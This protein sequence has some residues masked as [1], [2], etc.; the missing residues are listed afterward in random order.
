MDLLLKNKKLFLAVVLVTAFI[1]HAF[2]AFRF[3][4][5]GDSGGWRL[6]GKTGLYGGQFGMG[7]ST[8]YDGDCPLL[9]SNWPPLTYHYYIGMRWVYENLNPMQLPQWGFYKLFPVIASVG[10]GYLIYKFAL[11]YRLKNPIFFTA[12]Y[13]FHPLSLYV[14]AYHGQRESVWL[15]FLLLSL[16]IMLKFKRYFWFAVIFAVS[17]SIKLPPLL[18]APFLFLALPTLRNKTI[19]IFTVPF[20]F[21]LLS[22]PEI[23][24][25]TENVFRQVFLYRGEVGWWGFAGLAAKIDILIGSS[26]SDSVG[27]INKALQYLI[28]ISA[29]FYFYRRKFNVLEGILGVLII[30][31]V[32]SSVFAPQYMLWPLPFIV[33]LSNKYKKYFYAYSLAAVYAAMNS[34]GIFGLGL[35]E[36][37]LVNIP[38]NLIYYKIPFL[39]YPM[40][41]YF[42]LWIVSFLFLLNIIRK[43]R[44][45]NNYVKK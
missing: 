3:E 45:R 30:I 44:I 21:F 1:L 6:A 25:Y 26:L 16:Y 23:I 41:L 37:L 20:V 2:I 5:T 28:I 15:F 40:D 39:S 35:I 13:V 32:F 8:V 36:F 14:S 10:I 42:P 17:V 4:G 43:D 34:Y 29:S 11:F 18:L 38:Q 31:F 12:I 22:L 19:F 24:T 33:L 9:C 7:N 27:S